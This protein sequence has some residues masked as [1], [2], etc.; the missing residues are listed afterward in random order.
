LKIKSFYYG[1]FYT[2]LASVFWGVPQPLFFNEIKFIPSIEVSFHRGFWS[3]I[4][5][6][7]IIILTGRINEFFKIF[8]SN[9]KIL[10]LSLSAILITINW[11]G[12]IFAVSID[13]V[14]DASMGYYMTPMISII[15]GYFFLN[16]K[17]TKL[18]FIS[19]LMIFGSLIFLLINLKTL[20]LLAI[21]IGMTWG[22]YGLLRKQI[23]VSAEIG[24]L[25][26]SALISLVAA[27]YLIYLNII[28]KG[29]FLHQATYT[30]TLLIL[31]GAIT[32]FPLFFFNLGLK[33]IPLGFAGVIFFLTPSLHFITSIF[34]LNEP[35][36]IDKLISFIIIWA[37]VAIFII[38][39]FREEKISESNTQLLD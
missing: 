36:S 12:F 10:F 14:Q 23:N 22:V 6:L 5:L 1:I 15:L 4:F 13:R 20:P 18:K 3:F 26:E 34:I 7:F 28:G 27:P 29:F 31:T 30:S 39:I 19:I 35:L 38:D 24:L 21:L 25:Y 8:Q 2:V 16:E 17:I 33:F 37:A 32:I 9:K 11:T